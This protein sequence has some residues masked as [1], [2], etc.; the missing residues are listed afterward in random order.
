VPSNLTLSGTILS[1]S[2]ASTDGITSYRAYRGATEIGRTTDASTLSLDISSGL[3]TRIVSLT[4]QP[5][6]DTTALTASSPLVFSTAVPSNL[7]LSGTILS[8]SIAS[9]NGITSY[10]VTRIVAGNEIEIGRTSSGTTFSLDI[11]NSIIGNEHRFYVIAYSN[12]NAVSTNLSPLLFTPSVPTN[13]T[14]SGTILSWSISSTNGITSYRAYR[15]TT[16]IGR[17]TD[18]TTFSLDISSSIFGGSNILTVLPYSSTNALLVSS[19]AYVSVAPTNLTLSGTVLSWSIAVTAGITSYRVFNN[20]NG[21]EI[22]IGRTSSGTTFSLDISNG[23]VALQNTLTVLPYSG[24]NSLN[25]SDPLVFTVTPSVPSNLTLSR[26]VLSWS[27]D[28]TVVITFYIIKNN[29]YEIGRT[30]DASTFS[31]DISNG[32]VLG[33]NSL[34]VIPQSVTDELT[35]SS[36]LEFTPSVPSNLTLSGTVL[37]W[38]NEDLFVTY[39]ITNASGYVI[40]TTTNTFFDLLYLPF[41]SVQLYVQSYANPEGIMIATSSAYVYAPIIKTLS[42]VGTTDAFI[43]KYNPNGS[44]L[45]A[46]K[47]GDNGSKSARSIAGDAY[48]NV[49]VTGS[50]NGTLTNFYNASGSSVSLTLANASTDSFLVKY[51]PN[52]E[53]LWAS[54]IGGAGVD[55]GYRVTLDSYGNV[56]I[57]GNYASNPMIFY[58]ASGSGVTQTQTLTNAG[59]TDVFV[60]K[61]NPSG[62]V[63]WAAQI[64]GAGSEIG[65]GVTSD[66]YGNIYLTGQ[67]VSNP[68]T[69]YNA[70]GSGV[71]QSQTLTNAGIAGTIDAFIAKYNP[72]GAVLWAAQIAGAGSDIGNV[73]TSDAYG[74]IYVNGQYA[75]NPITFYNAS[76]SGVTQ[77]QTLTNAGS[78]DVFIAKYNPSGAVSWAA[79]IAGAGNDVGSGIKTDS[80]GNIFVTGSYSSV[81]N[82]ITFYNA[83]GSGVLETKTLTNTGNN[84]AYI[85]KYNPSGAIVWAAQIDC[86]GSDAGN[87]VTSDAYGNIYLTGQYGSNPITFYNAS[88]SGVTKTQTLTNAGSNDAFIA[89]YNP[90]GAVLWAAQIGGTTTD[91]GNGVTTDASA[92]VYVTGTYSSNSVAV[93]S[94]IYVYLSATPYGVNGVS[95]GINGFAGKK[96]TLYL[97]TILNTSGILVDG[98]SV[99]LQNLSEGTHS[100]YATLTDVL[101]VGIS[102][103]IVTFI[104]D[105]PQPPSAPTLTTITTS[106]TTS[107]SITF[108]IS[109]ESNATYF[110]YT[111]DILSVSGTLN[112]AGLATVARTGLAY[113]SYSF[114]ATQMNVYGS[115]SEQSSTINIVVSQNSGG[116]GGGGVFDPHVT[117]PCF[118]ANAPVLTPTGYIKISKLSAGDEITTSDGRTVRIQKVM[119]KKVA[120][121]PSTNPY[122][123]PKGMYGA[124]LNLAISPNHRIVMP[125][126]SMV[127]ACHLGLKQQERASDDMIEYYNLALPN[128]NSDNMV[129]AGVAVESLAPV[130]HITMT[131][132]E[133]KSRLVTKYGKISPAILAKIEKTCRILSDGRVECPVLTKT[134]TKTA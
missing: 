73:V 109:G 83:S 11:S 79:K 114:Y 47:F 63:L 43:A 42:K 40:G 36:P 51:N 123:I 16:E 74:N 104:V 111:N 30:T 117:V 132:G 9:T 62:A 46:T 22:E 3:T 34:N 25:A 15:D 133:F 18:A 53:V 94:A 45:W 103:E 55:N 98:T 17:T 59:S 4:V 44:L 86:A 80:N 120:A 32:I 88:G 10:R 50:S 66:A 78:N 69:F 38:S 33:L 71:T 57:I 93:L 21:N 101:G 97:D 31:L 90:S 105:T 76:G 77:T 67:Y 108:T 84:D 122:T 14:L 75:S 2:I 27:I 119:H 116:G 87:G 35:A 130:R 52:G 72:S 121:G 99:I 28:S 49:Y 56:Y 118:L 102:S 107:T 20:V 124:T 5:Y 70:S 1:W 131:M 95:I 61:Y 89:K 13:L 23:I 100:V 110:F 115:T 24:T 12:T 82:P 7:T 113:N 81:S 91:A 60:A 126:G 39:K 26:T 41:N 68:I 64:A 112:N 128:W 129:V 6:S 92:N 106:P 54:Q 58:N 37:S 85:A 134:Q 29:A 65:Y 125:D 96:Y 19:P 48:N 127:E 8:W